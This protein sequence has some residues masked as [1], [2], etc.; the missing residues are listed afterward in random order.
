MDFSFQLYRGFKKQTLFFSG[1]DLDLSLLFFCLTGSGL[2]GRRQHSRSALAADL[3]RR[4]KEMMAG[5]TS[6]IDP[7]LKRRR[8]AAWKYKNMILVHGILL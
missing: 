5:N 4:S 7:K 3:R 1:R 2:S 8:I 6:S